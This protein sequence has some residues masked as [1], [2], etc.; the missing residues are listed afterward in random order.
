MPLTLGKTEEEGASINV[1]Y[2]RRFVP[3]KSSL[4]AER[5]MLIISGTTSTIMAFLTRSGFL[6]TIKI[7]FG[8][9]IVVHN[10]KIYKETADPSGDPFCL[11]FI[12]AMMKF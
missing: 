7:P 5:K 10:K 4:A 12:F 9:A 1:I 3:E 8:V 2:G 6:S 11:I